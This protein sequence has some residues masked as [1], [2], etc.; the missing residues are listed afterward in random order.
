MT[1]DLPPALENEPELPDHLVFYW[2]AFWGLHAD[3]PPS[4]G[5]VM[6]IP[7]SAL[8]RFGR[9]Y[10]VDDLDAFDRLSTFVREMDRV[11]LGWAHKQ[12]KVA[13]S[14]PAAS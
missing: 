14:K 10:Q 3:R 1:G 7:F 12:K 13:A 5:G 9:R 4:F 6:P 11:Y 8:D 2:R